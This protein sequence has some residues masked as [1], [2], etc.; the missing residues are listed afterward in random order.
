MTQHRPTWPCFVAKREMNSTKLTNAITPPSLKEL[1]LSSPDPTPVSCIYTAAS[2][3]S[4]FLKRG[5]GKRRA[6][7]GLEW[8]LVGGGIKGS[9]LSLKTFSCEKTILEGVTV[10]TSSFLSDVWL[11][12]NGE[13]KNINC[14]YS[15]N[16]WLASTGY[17][18]I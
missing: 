5:N 15:G 7:M 18:Y 12:L 1:G 13:R 9:H 3:N 2:G 8:C 11:F 17:I 6:Q 14:A 4:F 16:E 10:L